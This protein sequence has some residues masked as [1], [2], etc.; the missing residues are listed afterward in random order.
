MLLS[1]IS[2]RDARL[3]GF[4]HPSSR[5]LSMMTGLFPV[6]PTIIRPSRSARMEDDL[7]I[8]LRAILSANANMPQTTDIDLSMLENGEAVAAR[9]EWKPRHQRNKVAL[10]PEHLETYFELQRQCRSRVLLLLQTLSTD[11]S[12]LSQRPFTI[13]TY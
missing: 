5:P 13:D 3:L 2:D 6:P 7:S 9:P 12:V 4:G 1:L 11:R 8:R 10:V